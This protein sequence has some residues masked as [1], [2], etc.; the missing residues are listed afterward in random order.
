MTEVNH[1]VRHLRLFVSFF[2]DVFL[3]SQSRNEILNITTYAALFIGH[4]TAVGTILRFVTE[5]VIN[6]WNEVSVEVTLK[7]LS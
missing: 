1:L 2:H 7:V 4:F 6:T 5:S 3:F